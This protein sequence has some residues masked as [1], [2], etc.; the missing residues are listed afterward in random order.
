MIRQKIRCTAIGCS[1]FELLASPVAVRQSLPDLL[2]TLVPSLSPFLFFAPSFSV[3]YPFPPAHP[4]RLRCCCRCCCC[5]CRRLL[6]RAS[7]AAA[8]AATAAPL[9]GGMGAGEK[10]RKNF[11]KKIQ[12]RCHGDRRALT[13]I[14][15]PRTSHLRRRRRRPLLVLLRRLVLRPFRSSLPSPPLSRH[16][17][18]TPS[19]SQFLRLYA[20]PV[21]L[22]V[23]II[24]VCEYCVFA[25]ERVQGRIRR[26]GG[27]GDGAR[28]Q[29]DPYRGGMRGGPGGRTTRQPRYARSFVRSPGGGEWFVCLFRE[30]ASAAAIGKNFIYMI[31]KCFSR[32][33]ERT[34]P[35]KTRRAAPS[36]PL[37]LFLSPRRALL[38]FYCTPARAREGG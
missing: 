11:E 22:T 9:L 17:T 23:C 26:P 7:L 6:R 24:C 8:A 4:A 29:F 2:D 16:G 1:Q 18:T 27:P 19:L 5:R 10:G 13:L 35:K 12:F 31:E 14:K 37:L 36:R 28:F 20:R 25:H 3:P 33:K 34:A 15:I 38:P 32:T 21:C 30:R